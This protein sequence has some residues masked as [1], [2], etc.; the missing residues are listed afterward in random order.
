MSWYFS[1]YAKINID[2]IL[3]LRCVYSNEK[4]TRKDPI[5]YE[6]EEKVLHKYENICDEIKASFKT[7]YE[8]DE[9]LLAK[10]TDFKQKTIVFL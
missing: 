2:L 3:F 9:E 8:K 6:L 5:S 7:T 4:I 1:K 10:T